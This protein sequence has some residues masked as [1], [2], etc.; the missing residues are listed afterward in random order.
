MKSWEMAWYDQF[1][2]QIVVYLKSGLVKCFKIF[3]QNST[4][5]S[6]S[7]T[8]ALW[9]GMKFLEHFFP[10]SRDVYIPSPSWGN[11][12]QIIKLAKLTPKSYR[13]YDPKT[14]G[15]D[16]QGALEDIN[17]SSKL[18]NSFLQGW[19]KQFTKNCP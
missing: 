9:I 15:L 1:T 11:H 3:L 5:Q 14:C 18:R 19:D 7:G 16:F 13:Y 4:V 17:V 2:I 10:N 12:A 6:I 8:G